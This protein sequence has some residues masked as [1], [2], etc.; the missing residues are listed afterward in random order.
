MDA[1][2]II[3]IKRNIGDKIN[4]YASYFDV[5]Y[6]FEIIY[7]LIPL[8]VLYG[9][10]VSITF[11][12][13]LSVLLSFHI[14]FLFFK[15]GIN[16]WIQLFLMEL[17]I[18]YSFPF[19]INL[20]RGGYA[21]SWLETGVTVFRLFICCFELLFLYILTE[22]DVIAKFEPSSHSRSMPLS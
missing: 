18:A 2:I 19:F 14:I 10:F 7:L 1:S 5:F 22:E 6:Y 20:L 15:K 4:I 8:N 17:H 12:I 11:G 21:D 9:G 13:A 16:R 3:G